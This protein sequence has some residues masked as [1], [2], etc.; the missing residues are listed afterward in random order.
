MKAVAHRPGTF[1]SKLSCQVPL[2][3]V[4]APAIGAGEGAGAGDPGPLFVEKQWEGKLA[5]SFGLSSRLFLLGTQRRM[6]A[7]ASQSVSTHTESSPLET[8]VE[9]RA[10]AVYGMATLD[11]TL[12]PIEKIKIWRL[13]IIVEQHIRYADERGRALREGNK[14]R[15]KVLEAQDICS[16]EELD[17]TDDEEQHKHKHKHK[18]DFIRIP[19][20]PTPL[21]PHRSPLL[22]HVPPSTDPSTLAGPG[23]YTLSVNIG[24]PGCDHPSGGDSGPL[25]FSVKQK[26]SSVKVDH[27]LR[28]VM[29]V[30][31]VGD[32]D[33][34]DHGEG[35]KKR[36]FDI[37][38]QT[39]I[40]VLSVS[41]AFSLR[42]C[43]RVSS[44]LFIAPKQ[45][46]CIPEYQT[47]PTYCQIMEDILQNRA[48]CP[49]QP[50]IVVPAEHGYRHEISNYLG[51]LLSPSSPSS[52][53]IE[54]G[55]NEHRH[56]REHSRS[57]L[58]TQGSSHAT[59]LQSHPPSPA[60]W[61]RSP[62]FLQSQHRHSHSQ[63]YSVSTFHVRTHSQAPT[64]STPHASRPPSPL[65][66][67][68]RLVSG[69]ESEAGEAPPSYE[70]VASGP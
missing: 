41:P 5:Y 1:T 67:Y 46:R 65:V 25:H 50:S 55:A 51:H 62:S 70:S 40:T 59:P 44:Y 28:L 20:L 48:A 17:S 8:E 26:S 61:N 11:I 29:R 49:C 15:V 33:T 32:A 23:P 6:G 18:E 27:S 58:R 53:E 34:S 63:S 36:L 37:A 68:E 9:V 43:V 13:D 52:F 19:L 24:L 45:C 16:A 2:L 14:S 42:V 12:L 22:R 47:L 57:P 35:E 30:E 56:G 69:L 64:V 66:R 4:A 31:P 21:S 38:V 54:H 39:P 10:E 7:T 60:S 3:V